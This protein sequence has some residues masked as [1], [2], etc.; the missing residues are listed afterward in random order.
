MKQFGA[1]FDL[2]GVLIDSESRYTV[3]WDNIESI[4]PT[5]IPDYA[6]AIKGTTLEKILLHYDSK[7]VRDDITSRLKDFQ[8]HMKYELY[9]GVESFL[10]SLYN[11]GIPMAL[12]TSSDSL[13]M[14][15]LRRQLPGFLDRFKFVVDGDMVKHSKPDPEG[16]R[17]GAAKI[18][19]APADCCVFE[20]SLQGLK[21]GRA[22]GG[23]VVAVATTYPRATVE[24]LADLTVD[25]LSELSPEQIAEMWNNN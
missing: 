19:I 17:L 23:K 16:Y 5:G 15:E 20:D 25:L 3:F 12:V 9:P 13:K 10:D 14:E 18:G 24:P 1:L 21:A 22:A 8:L 7:A 4:Y 2:D 11:S 6:C